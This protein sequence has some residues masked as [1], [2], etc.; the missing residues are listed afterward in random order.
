MYVAQALKL[1]VSSC[2]RTREKA[3]QNLKQAVMLFLEEAEKWARSG[4]S[5]KKP[6]TAKARR[7]RNEVSSVCSV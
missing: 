1:D 6:G 5:S 7:Y 4:R 3:L 2:G